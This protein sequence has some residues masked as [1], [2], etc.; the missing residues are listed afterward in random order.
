MKR[1]LV[2]K[3]GSTLVLDDEVVRDGE[4]E[5][6]ASSC[7]TARPSASSPPAPSHWGCDG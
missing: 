3:L 5:R 4:R 7:A 2:V 1:P 6:S